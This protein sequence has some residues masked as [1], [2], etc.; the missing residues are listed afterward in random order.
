[1]SFVRKRW[2][3]WFDTLKAWSE[4]MANKGG[5]WMPVEVLWLIVEYARVQHCRLY[6]LRERDFDSCNFVKQSGPFGNSQIVGF[7]SPDLSFRGADYW[8]SSRTLGEDAGPWSLSVNMTS[9]QEARITDIRIGIAFKPEF[10][11]NGNEINA[12]GHVSFRF[13]QHHRMNLLTFQNY[14]YF[15]KQE[16]FF[17]SRHSRPQV[18]SLP[19]GLFTDHD[20]EDLKLFAQRI[21]QLSVR[22]DL[23]S[24][25]IYFGRGSR[26]QVVNLSDYF[27]LELPLESARPFIQIFGAYETVAFL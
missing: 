18:Y 13:S 19:D 17:V 6:N 8:I 10:D 25:R 16:V 1:M 9:E 27:P 7:C 2:R 22:V 4:E 11:K 15:Q 26:I 20:P 14:P 3:P 24:R 12:G 23:L 21:Q 5:R